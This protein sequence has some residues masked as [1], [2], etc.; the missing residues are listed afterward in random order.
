MLCR[1]AKRRISLCNRAAV[2]DEPEDEEVAEDDASDDEE[3]EED[4]EVPAK[5]ARKEV[6]WLR[7]PPNACT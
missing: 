1:G 2:D 4:E 7:F 6:R 3:G 5:R